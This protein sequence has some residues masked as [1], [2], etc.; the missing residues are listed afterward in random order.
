MSRTP[1]QSPLSY[2]ELT[3]PVYRRHLGNLRGM[4]STA[5]DHCATRGLNETELLALQATA[6]M[7][8]FVRQ[9][10]MTTGMATFVVANLAG[11]SVLTVP[12]VET[13]LGE[14]QLRIDRVDGWL[15]QVA[16][17]EYSDLPSQRY[18]LPPL[19]GKTV[20]LPVE[21][22]V[23]DFALPNFFFHLTVSYTL[24][25]SFG[26]PLGKSDFIGELTSE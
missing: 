6:D 26:I 17:A 24:M 21:R 16:P 3:V 10:Q 8:P 11:R 1:A 4:L 23:T 20:S 25:R 5:E 22:F 2:Y 12:D 15:A 19:G 13:S 9:V 7:F 14:L 18:S